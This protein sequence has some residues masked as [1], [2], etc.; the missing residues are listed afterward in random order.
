ME[1]RFRSYLTILE[2]VSSDLEQLTDLARRKTELVKRDDL[3]ALDD[4][5]NQEQALA[6]A[7]RGFEQKRETLLRELGLAEVPLSCMAGHFPGA[8]RAEAEQVITTLQQR[9]RTYQDC[10]GQ[11]RSLL[12]HS[13]REI[14]VTL[15]RMGAEPM[16]GPGYTAR[17]VSPPPSMK[18]DFHA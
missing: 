12:E 1:D 17:E 8:M 15:A 18:T 3:L 5:L 13:L 10:A 9:Y 14:E 6:L 16:D 11:A 7:F 2:S 4:V